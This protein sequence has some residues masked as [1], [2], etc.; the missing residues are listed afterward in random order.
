MRTLPRRQRGD[1]LNSARVG[2]APVFAPASASFRTAMIC[3]SVN[4]LPNRNGL[5]FGGQ[6]IPGLRR[7]RARTAPV[8]DAGAYGTRRSVACQVA[9]SSAGSPSA[10]ID[11]RISHR[12]TRRNAMSRIQHAAAW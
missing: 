8:R 11:F 1:R 5:V 3:P 9:V 12:G 4:R 2:V 10:T 7:R 6:V